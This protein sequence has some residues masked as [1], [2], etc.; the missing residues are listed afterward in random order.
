MQ[1]TPKPQ[2]KDSKCK[3]LLLEVLAV[4]FTIIGT[5]AQV[6]GL[7]FQIADYLKQPQPPSEAPCVK[8]V[9]TEK[10]SSD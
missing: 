5:L 10:T 1:D 2:T 4:L 9:Q 3:V 7:K 8:V 6:I